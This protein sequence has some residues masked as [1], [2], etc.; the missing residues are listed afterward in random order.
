[1]P[2]TSSTEFFYRLSPYHDLIH[3]SAST[4][5]ILPSPTGKACAHRDELANQYLE[6]LPYTPYRCRRKRCSPG[7]PQN[8]GHG[9]RPDG[10]RQNAHRQAALFEALHSGKQAYYTTP[11]DRAYRAEVQRD[12]NCRP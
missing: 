6:Q 9:V 1:L 4:T 10:Y 12:A 5:F 2:D 8:R 11:A 7:S 3:R